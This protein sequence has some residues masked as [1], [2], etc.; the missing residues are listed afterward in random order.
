MRSEPGQSNTV[1]EVCA[2]PD[3]FP[4]SGEAVPYLCLPSGKQLE[5]PHAGVLA[6]HP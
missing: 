4:T 1:A 2:A 6:L 3:G 5:S